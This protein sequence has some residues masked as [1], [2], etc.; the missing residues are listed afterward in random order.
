MVLTRLAVG[1]EPLNA[2]DAAHR[3][4]DPRQPQA[5]RNLVPPVRPATRRPI[6]RNKEL[7]KRSLLFSQTAE[8]KVTVQLHA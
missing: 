5:G 2:V 3:S 7:S 6:K 8:T 1:L 4:P